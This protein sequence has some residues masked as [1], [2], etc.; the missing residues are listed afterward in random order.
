MFFPAN[1]EW[2]HLG[3]Y[4]APLV[5]DVRKLA[6]LVEW[7]GP[8]LRGLGNGG[9]KGGHLP[10]PRDLIYRQC[11][12]FHNTCDTTGHKP[13][14]ETSAAVRQLTKNVHWGYL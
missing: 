6:P 14:V 3:S 1:P 11:I 9:E 10:L 5:R 2:F 8:P 4:D 7:S 12:E 13:P